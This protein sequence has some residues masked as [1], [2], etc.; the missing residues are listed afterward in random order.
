MTLND[1]AGVADDDAT[2][3]V[4]P[5]NAAGTRLDVFLTEWFSSHRVQLS[6]VQLRKAIQEE[7][8]LVDGR[9]TKVAYRL[10]PGEQIRVRLPD[11]PPSGPQPEPIPLIR[12]YED[13]NLIAINKPPGMVVHPSKGHGSG[14]LASALA[15]HFQRL[16]QAGGPFRP[17][18]VHRLDR[19]TSGVI[20]AAKN[21]R[22]HMHIAKQFEAKQIEKTYWALVAG[23]PDR[24]ADVIDRP[25]GMHPYQR[26]KMTIRHDHPTSREAQTFYQVVER[27]QGFTRLQVAPRT[28]RTHQIRVHLSSIGHPILCDRLYSGHSCLSLQEIHP[29]AENDRVLLSRQA[30]HAHRLK[31]T[32]PTTGEQLELEAPLPDDLEGLLEVLRSYRQ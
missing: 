10:R 1:D 32:H 7:G 6:R 17:G 27:F 19:D 20:I 30:L 13:D 2:Q 8:V 25:I 18:I 22:V 26:E 23:E 14:T 11:L 9:R 3:I 5:D 28:G 15:Y 29:R 21:D 16:S 12:L 4:V 24:D 31:L